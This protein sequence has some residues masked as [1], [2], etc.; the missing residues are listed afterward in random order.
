V[1]GGG[2]ALRGGVA[3]EPALR[4]EGAEK[5]FGDT[6]AL[7][8][9]S[10][11]LARGEWLALLGPNG[12]GKTTLVRAIADRVRLDAG[13]LELLGQELDASPAARAARDRLGVVPQEVALYPQLTATENLRLWGELSGAAADDLDLRIE[14][15]LEWIGL[16]GRRHDRVATFSGG[17]KRRLNIACGVLHRPQVVLLDE[18]TV[19]VDP[20]SRV[21]IWQML[22]QL[23]DEGAALL[24]TTHQLDEAQQV[25]DRVVIIDHGRSIARGTLQELV[26]DTIGSGRRVSLHL[27]R[28]VAPPAGFVLDDT[29]LRG[30]IDDVA[31]DLPGLLR[32]VATAGARVLDVEIEAPSLQ[33]VFLHLTGREL[34]E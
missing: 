12:A 26:R 19:G 27:D 4:V 21:R 28:A 15:A 34:R 13:R 16:E 23:R 5:R 1:R 29:T 10:L 24:L 25:A 7:T 31:E 6:R 32:R 14:W 30:S 33:A 9:A 11:E 20:Q 3:G 17:M 2:R 22:G 8:G 18:P